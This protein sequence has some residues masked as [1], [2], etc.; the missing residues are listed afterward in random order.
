MKKVLV[1]HSCAPSPL[2]L[3]SRLARGKAQ[4][5]AQF[6][7]PFKIK[8]NG[9]GAAGYNEASGWKGSKNT[10]KS[11]TT[12]ICRGH[13]CLPRHFQSI[14]RKT[15]NLGG[16]TGVTRYKPASLLAVLL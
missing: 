2:S 9:V 15:E 6:S 14:N 5:A 8:V 16:W 11:Q 13:A 7:G 4:R 3:V 1:R 10:E 12:M